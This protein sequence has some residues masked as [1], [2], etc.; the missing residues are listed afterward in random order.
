MKEMEPIEKSF[1][2]ITNDRSP[3]QPT[4]SADVTFTS[5]PKWDDAKGCS[6]LGKDYSHP[7]SHS[8]EIETE[9]EP[10]TSEERIKNL[11]KYEPIPETIFLRNLDSFAALSEQSFGTLKGSYEALVIKAL[12]CGRDEYLSR[13]G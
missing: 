12:S 4:S 5:L 1:P 6:I 7:R 13:T 2:Q 11:K 10:G 3:A 9:E 8:K